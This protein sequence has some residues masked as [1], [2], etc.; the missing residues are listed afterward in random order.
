MRMMNNFKQDKGVAGLTIL[1]SLITF[2]FVIGFLV[3]VFSLMGGGM[4]ESTTL[5]AS[6][7]ASTVDTTLTQLAEG[8]LGLILTECAGKNQGTLSSI[9]S[10]YNITTL[11][12]PANYTLTSPCNL[13]F[14]ATSE[15]NTSVILNATYTYTFA[16]AGWDVMN[17]TVEGIG[18]SVDWFDIFIVIGA[19]VVLILLTVIIII[20]IRGSGLMGD[21]ASQGSNRNIGSA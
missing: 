10:V 9:D 15:F 16:G 13:T 14:T 21:G 11:V 5:S 1:L 18:G 17:D 4:K 2:L 19:M 6:D 12:D 20:S 3:M 7:S 8:E